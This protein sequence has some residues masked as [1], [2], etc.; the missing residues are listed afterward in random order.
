MERMTAEKALA[1]L[2]QV[3]AERGKN[4]IYKG[5]PS[6]TIIVSDCVYAVRIGRAA[7]T[8]SCGVG[9]AVQ[10]WHPATFKR[11]AKDE[12]LRGGAPV[13]E[14]FERLGIPL[15]DGADILLTEFQL[16][17]DAGKRYGDALRSAKSVLAEHRRRHPRS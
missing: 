6:D 10:L 7:A 5:V 17:Q 8:P 13:E 9:L 4:F 3:V 16:Q 2:E 11:L 1:L 15:D 12:E 14:M